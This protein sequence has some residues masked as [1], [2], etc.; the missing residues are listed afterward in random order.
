MTPDRARRRIDQRGRWSRVL[1]VTLIAGSAMSCGVSQGDQVDAG[2]PK[3]QPTATQTSS[4]SDAEEAVRPSSNAAAL[5][6]DLSVLAEH[7]GDAR[8]VSPA[9]TVDKVVRTSEAIVSG[10]IVSVEVEERPT[11]MR[12]GVETATPVSELWLVATVEITDI[13]ATVAGTVPA[14]SITWATS[15]WAGESGS[16]YLKE[17]MVHAE[18]AADHLRSAESVMLFLV[19]SPFQD[20]WMHVPWPEGAVVIDRASGDTV[21]LHPNLEAGEVSLWHDPERLRQ[22]VEAARSSIGELLAEARGPTP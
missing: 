21:T 17:A 2:S 11:S 5:Q 10:T 15:V 4:K 7:A 9:S 1:A 22:D 6:R 14:E 3:G 12:T 18:D 20:G 19:S 16:Q 13:H 8:F